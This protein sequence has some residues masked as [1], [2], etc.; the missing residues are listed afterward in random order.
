[1]TGLIIK[2]IGGFYYV[3]TE[4]GIFECKGRGAFKN[5]GIKLQVGDRV[6]ISEVDLS[7]EAKKR[8]MEHEG[9]IEEIMERKNHFI[10]PPLVNVDTFAV[11]FAAKDPE[12]TFSLIDKF[13]VMAEMNGVE[14]IIVMNKCDLVSDE[15]RES[16]RDIYKGLY[17]LVEVSAETGEGLDKLESMITGRTL[18][19][20]GPSGVGKST[21]INALIPDA[22]METGHVSQKTLRGRHT[23]RHVEIFETKGGGLVYDTPGFTSFEI[24]EAGEEDLQLY[25]PDFEPYR[26]S[27]YY[28]NC[29]HLKEPD[30]AVRKAVKEGKISKV[31][32]LS[33]KSNMEEIKE[34]RKY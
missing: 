18:A 27:C 9:V 16:Y 2:G 26:G 30:C 12:P 10:R 29:R 15:L 25:Y 13:L 22:E 4:E 28:D 23:T 24:L 8:G 6:V 31:R 7:R 32:Y 14:A 19:F 34:K 17:P 5:K 20:A 33:Y 21:L 3:K 11:T 1:M